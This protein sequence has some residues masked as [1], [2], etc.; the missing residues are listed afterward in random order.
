M[1]DII[2]NSLIKVAKKRITY[3]HEMLPHAEK[4]EIV[5]LIEFI[6][7]GLSEAKLRVLTWK[8]D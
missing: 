5:S 7:V 4:D 2:T 8:D 1:L 6:E 3:L